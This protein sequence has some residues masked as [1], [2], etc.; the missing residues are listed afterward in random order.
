MQ[1]ATARIQAGVRA[2]TVAPGTQA[3]AKV[4]KLRAN[5][6]R[7]LENNKWQNNT[8]AVTLQS[9]QSAMLNKGVPRITDG[10][11][12]AQSKVTNFATALLY[13]EGQL[14]S[15]IQQMPKITPQDSKNRMIAWFDGMS[16]F[17]YERAQA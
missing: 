9:W 16:L 13:Y 11:N 3:V 2:V 6:L 15:N 10:V 17:R 4:D 12:A 5:F 1:N 8:A 14:Q 7:S